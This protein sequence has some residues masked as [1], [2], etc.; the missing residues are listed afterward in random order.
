MAVMESVNV[1]VFTQRLMNK[2]VM[3][4]KLQTDHP[5]YK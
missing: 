5:V 1:L 4:G 3:F 2:Y